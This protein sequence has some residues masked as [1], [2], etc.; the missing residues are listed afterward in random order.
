M[1]VFS[2]SFFFWLDVEGRNGRRGKTNMFGH[3]RKRGRGKEIEEW[4]EETIG[5]KTRREV[6]DNPRVVRLQGMKGD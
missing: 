1:Q 5:N 6:V 3:R 4:E 2:S